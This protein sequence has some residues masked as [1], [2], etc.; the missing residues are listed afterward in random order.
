M[1][2]ALQG[3]SEKQ[4]SNAASAESFLDALPPSESGQ[5]EDSNNRAV[6]PIP[7]GFGRG[8]GDFGGRGGRGGRGRGGGG[9]ER[10][11]KGKDWECPSCTNVNWSWRS[12]CNKCNTAKPAAILVNVANR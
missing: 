5:Y 8:R 11:V 4:S 2:D 1:W 9:L 10:D 3:N 7:M 6:A 12:N